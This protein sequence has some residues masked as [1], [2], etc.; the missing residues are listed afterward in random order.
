MKWMGKLSVKLATFAPQ[1]SAKF[2]HILKT[3]KSTVMTK[4]FTLTLVGVLMAIP[5]GYARDFSFTFKKQTCTY[6]VI[7]EDA[8]TCMTKTGT[9]SKAGNT[10][11]D[12]LIIP[13]EA[14]DGTDFY[15]VTTI[16]EYSFYNCKNLTDVTIPESVEFINGSAFNRCSGLTNVTIP[17]SVAYIGEN[18]FADCT[19][20][21]DFHIGECKSSTQHSGTDS[22]TFPSWEATQTWA[23]AS[24]SKTYSFE[25]YPGA[26][27][28]FTYRTDMA[29][30]SGDFNGSYTTFRISIDGK[31]VV[32]I[33]QKAQNGSYTHTFDYAGTAKVEAS[34][35][36]CRWGEDPYSYGEIYNIKLSVP[37]EAK[38]KEL[39]M[40][41]NAFTSSPIESL[42]LGKDLS[43][44]SVPFKNLVSLQEITISDEVDHIGQESFN[45]CT[46]LS[47]VECLGLMPPDADDDTFSAAAYRYATL[48][49]PTIAAGDYA[50]A[51]GWRMF[52]NVEENENGLSGLDEIYQ[53]S[54]AV[55]ACDGRV[56]IVGANGRQIKIHD[57]FGREIYA[58]RGENDCEVRSLL[59]GIYIVTIA[60]KS[61]KIML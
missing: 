19:A 4:K 60:E 61:T 46:D 38:N 41:N 24:Q 12:E 26:E 15:T 30:N 9:T 13:S 25:V 51:P 50:E 17:G 35:S 14:Y 43:P 23:S 55:R 57:I 6:T 8:K 18:A 53:T 16:G 22:K 11:T 42:Y 37:W 31:S 36:V 54:A 7:D 45:G 52:T 33:Q 56:E 48:K 1:L 32:N 20:L 47:M 21:T 59:P 27:L 2:E 49:V 28:T 3:I 5:I 44:A 29:Y 34:W 39:F 10:V 40:W 58:F